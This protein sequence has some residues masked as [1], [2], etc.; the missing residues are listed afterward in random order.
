MKVLPGKISCKHCGANIEYDFSD[1]EVDVVSP[2]MYNSATRYI[3]CP[4]CHHRIIF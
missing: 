3:T 1:V 4:L 2:D